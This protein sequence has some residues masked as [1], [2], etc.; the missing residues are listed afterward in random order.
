MKIVISGL[1]KMGKQIAK[2]L[3][4]N[5]HDV[6]TH[7][8]SIEAINEMKD[9]GINGSQDKSSV[10]T[11]FGSDMVILW[12]MIPQDALDNEIK[13]WIKVLPKGSIIIDGGNSDFRITRDRGKKLASLGYS[14]IDIGTSGGIWGYKN[15]FSMMIG[16]EKE[17]FQKIEPIIEALSKPNGGY[18]YF[19]ESGSGHFV[20]MVHNAIEYGMM[21]S[22]AEGFHLLKEG[23]YKIDL[24]LAG[25]VWQ[26]GSVIASWLNGLMAEGLKENPE[27]K[28]IEG[29]VAE[30]GEAKWALET[31]KEYNIPMP[32]I[33]SS[34]D[35]RIKS[36]SGRVN[37][38]TKLLALTRNAFGGHKINNK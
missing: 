27:L 1:G 2:K 24:A 3:H 9:F 13:E 5:N 7:N 28:G 15:G 38:A 20:K 10:I 32:S 17:V 25:D 8:R 6:F 12:I 35:V 33:S 37:F 22:L 21:Q 14:F 11:F 36:Q 34:F 29:I 30:S 23:P 4:E 31:A 19:G 16:G 26:S 18:Q